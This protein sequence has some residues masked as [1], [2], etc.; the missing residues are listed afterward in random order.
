MAARRRSG[1]TSPRHRSS[2]ARPAARRCLHAAGSTHSRRSAGCSIFSRTSAAYLPFAGSK[3]YK[4]ERS[5]VRTSQR[6]N[7]LTCQHSNRLPDHQAGLRASDAHG[8][9]NAGGYSVAERLHVGAFDE[10]DQVEAPGDGVDL[11]D[12]RAVE[13]HIRQLFDQIL[14]TSRFGLDQ[15]VRVDHSTPLRWAAPDGSHGDYP[16]VKVISGAAPVR[17]M[18]SSCSL[19][20]AYAAASGNIFLLTCISA[21]VESGCQN[22]PS[23]F[24]VSSGARLPMPSSS[25]SLEYPRFAS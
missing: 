15:N 9:R 7:L 24:T 12:H 3:V 23:R 17:A 14:H 22:T 4:F 1:R 8:A 21:S 16:Q 13:L 19:T 5:S 20:R 25:P 11:L 10:S 2:C 6:A 18:T